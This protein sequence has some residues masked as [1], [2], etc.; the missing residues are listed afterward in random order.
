M[1]V[2]FVADQDRVLF[3]VNAGAQ[4]ERAELRAWLTRRLVQRLW[5]ALLEA[6]ARSALRARPGAVAAAREMLIGLEREERLK[7]A[8]FTGPFQSPAPSAAGAF[9]LGEAP[10]LVTQVD[11][12]LRADGQW[13]LVLRPAEGRGIEIHMGPTLLHAFCKLLKQACDKAD[14]RLDLALPGE[15]VAQ[16]PAVRH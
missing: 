1:Q 12:G 7:T 14:W 10:I 11:I 4:S 3:R 15:A 8:N 13:R 9:P 5:P 2:A 6:L 16:A